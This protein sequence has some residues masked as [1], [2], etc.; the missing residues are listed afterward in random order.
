MKS[1]W[2]IRICWYYLLNFLYIYIYIIIYIYICTRKIVLALFH[3]VSPLFTSRLTKKGCM[4]NRQSAHTLW[5]QTKEELHVAVKRHAWWSRE[6]RP[7]SRTSKQADTPEIVQCRCNISN[8]SMFFQCLVYITSY[9]CPPR[10][11]QHCQQQHLPHHG[12]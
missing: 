11:Q 2:C 9:G 8:E 1:S 4:L 6:S 7:T 12:G 3:R 10:S 5:L